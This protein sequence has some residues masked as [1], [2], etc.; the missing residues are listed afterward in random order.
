V[1][2]STRYDHMSA[3]NRSFTCSQWLQWGNP[4]IPSR[5]NKAVLPGTAT[6]RQS[7]QQK[8]RHMPLSGTG[9]KQRKNSVWFHCTVKEKYPVNP[10]VTQL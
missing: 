10:I 8:S 4:L 6:S 3:L 7:L 9:N 5:G 2:L 1:V